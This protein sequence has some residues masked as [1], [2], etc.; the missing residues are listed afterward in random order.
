MA[1]RVN[2]FETDD[3]KK[4][5]DSLKSENDKVKRMLASKEFY[6]L[7][8]DLKPERKAKKQKQNYDSL[9]YLKELH[10]DKII[11]MINKSNDENYNVNFKTGKI[12]KKRIAKSIEVQPETKPETETEPEKE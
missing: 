2:I 1:D 9:S 10:G 6:K 8:P 4:I 5:Y 7:H 12:T 3:Y 11:D